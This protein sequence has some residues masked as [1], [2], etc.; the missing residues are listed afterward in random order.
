[1]SLFRIQLRLTLKYFQVLM[2]NGI[3]LEKFA[4]GINYN[5]FL[6][7]IAFHLYFVVVFILNKEMNF[8]YYARVES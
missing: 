1:M 4:Q 5:Q 7:I 6:P 2:Y 3:Y 8:Q